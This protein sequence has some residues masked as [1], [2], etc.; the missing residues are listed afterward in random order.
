MSRLPVRP[1]RELAPGL[2]WIG[3]CLRQHPASSGLHACNSVYLVRGRHGAVLLEAGA[4]WDVDEIDA[5][6][7]AL[8]GPDTPLL[9]V[10]ISHQETPHAGGAG[11]LLARHPEATLRGD[12]RDMHLAFPEFEGRFEPMEVGDRID[13]GDTEIVAVD[14]LIRDLHSS[15]WAF[16]TRSRALFPGDGF[17]YSHHHRAG[18][19][20]RVA[21][22]V[23]DL[24][25]E[26]FTAI[27]AER[28]L[29]WTQLSDIEPYVEGIERMIEE[30]SVAVV[31]PTHG[32][33]ILDVPATLPKVLAG[34]RLGSAVGDARATPPT[35]EPPTIRLY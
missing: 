35:P 31:G 6:V 14:A 2:W 26:E 5:R 9:H 25:I 32:L 1:P 10:W 34:L 20:G 28:A 23:A 4:P 21:E 3:A 24:P 33:P 30:L 22:E 17:S 13:L 11:R 29:Y 19:C 8:L 16:D 27:F 18:E 15:Q 7:E 12:V